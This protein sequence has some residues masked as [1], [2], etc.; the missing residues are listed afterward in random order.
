MHEMLGHHEFLLRNYPAALAHYQVVI[1]QGRPS[2]SVRKRTV[3]CYI[4]SHAVEKAFELFT[5]LISED[6]QYVASGNSESEGCPCPEIIQEYE[7]GISQQP[8][9]LDMIALGMLW[10]YC[11]PPQSLIWFA[12]A[13]QEEPE[14]A[15]LAAAIGILKRSGIAGKPRAPSATSGGTNTMISSLPYH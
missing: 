9:V 15:S 8:Q 3:V 11:D 13:S 1:A 7:R 4:K 12:R 14:N 5:P 2:K 10:L 6:L